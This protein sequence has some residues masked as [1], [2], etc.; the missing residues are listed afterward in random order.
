VRADVPT[1]NFLKAKLT[2]TWLTEIISD[3]VKVIGTFSYSSDG[4][5]EYQLRQA[6]GNQ[7]I[8]RWTSRHKI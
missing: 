4:T 7:D 5:V 6:G 3:G 1:D 8:A 2:G